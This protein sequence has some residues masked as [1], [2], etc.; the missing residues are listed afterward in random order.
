MS[1]DY[2]PIRRILRFHL[3]SFSLDGSAYDGQVPFVAVLRPEIVAQFRF[4]LLFAIPRHFLQFGHGNL[5]RLALHAFVVVKQFTQDVV[6]VIGR[7]NHLI[8]IWCTVHMP[9]PCGW[10]GYCRCR[11]ARRHQP[12]RHLVL[13]LLHPA[14][15]LSLHARA[16]LWHPRKVDEPGSSKPRLP[17]LL[18]SPRP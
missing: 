13:P 12:A 14:E 15:P 5:L 3:D 8:I 16:P 11:C 9:L 7:N 2:S 10:Q 4:L 17:H 6:F 1:M 18:R